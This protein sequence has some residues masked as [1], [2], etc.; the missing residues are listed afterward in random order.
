M[1]LFVLNNTITICTIINVIAKINDITIIQTSN[2]GIYLQTI[3]QKNNVML[4][5]HVKCSSFMLNEEII[6][7]KINTKSL[8]KACL[9]CNNYQNMQFYYFPDEN[10]IEIKFVREFETKHFEMKLIN[11]K[12]SFLLM[13]HLQ[14]Q[15]IFQFTKKDIIYLCTTLFTLD[16]HVKIKIINKII[17]FKIDNTNFNGKISF[18]DKSLITSNSSNYFNK[19]FETKYWKIL[20]Y[21]LEITENIMISFNDKTPVK[22]HLTHACG[23]TEIFIL[24]IDLYD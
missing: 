5:S 15:N 12:V 20:K 10:K 6:D 14:F 18:E 19:T 16:N 3:E 11:K 8:Q 17:S 23:E 1:L 21:I 4:T 7:I 2:N 24:S 13:N 22:I 9:Y